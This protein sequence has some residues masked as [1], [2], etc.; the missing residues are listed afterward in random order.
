M[1][2]LV[3]FRSLVAFVALVGADTGRAQESN[4]LAPEVAALSAAAVSFALEAKL[5]DLAQP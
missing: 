5:P 1:K 2:N 3:P 4:G